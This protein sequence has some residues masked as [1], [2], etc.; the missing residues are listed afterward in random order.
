MSDTPVYN[1]RI[2]PPSTTGEVQDTQSANLAN[3]RANVIGNQWNAAAGV[4]R[5]V[6][7]LG[8]ASEGIF[9]KKKALT[10]TALYEERLLQLDGE[11]G[12]VP[13]SGQGG[14]GQLGNLNKNRDL[15]HD[16][17]SG[18]SA[19]PSEHMQNWTQARLDVLSEGLDPEYEAAFRQAAGE[20]L[21]K[22]GEK[23]DAMATGMAYSA[24][25]A[26]DQAV[27]TGYLKD[28]DLNDIDGSIESNVL[29]MASRINRGINMGVYGPEEGA[30][31]LEQFATQITGAHYMAASANIQDGDGWVDPLTS[32][33]YDG[34]DGALD[35]V[36]DKMATGELSE[37]DGTQIKAAINERD[38]E[39]YQVG[40]KVQQEMTNS[41][42][43]YF[44]KQMNLPEPPPGL[45]TSIINHKA[46]VPEKS[47]DWNRVGDQGTMNAL[48][49]ELDGITGSGDSEN[50][51][52]TIPGWMWTQFHDPTWDDVRAKQWLDNSGWERA[53]VSVEDYRWLYQKARDVD[54]LANTASIQKTVDLYYT[55]DLEAA[56]GD[57]VKTLQIEAEKMR[58]IGY[59][60]SQLERPE[61]TFK[62][63][64]T[65]LSNFLQTK[66]ED[67]I[68]R[69][70]VKDDVRKTNPAEMLGFFAQRGTL[71]GASAS[72]ALYENVVRMHEIH[73]EI[74]DGAYPAARGET[75]IRG[76]A[77]G[78]PGTVM[79]GQV[80]YKVW[81]DT[82]KN[83]AGGEIW[84]MAGVEKTPQ[85]G[86]EE[87]LLQM[88]EQPNLQ[89]K[90][91]WSPITRPGILDANST[92]KDRLERLVTTTEI[93]IENGYDWDQ[94]KARN[95]AA[96]VEENYSDRK[97]I[98]GAP[99]YAGISNHYYDLYKQRRTGI[100]LPYASVYDLMEGDL[101]RGR[102]SSA[103][104]ARTFEM[105][106][107]EIHDEVLK[108]IKND[109]NISIFKSNG[110][111]RRNAERA[112]SQALNWYGLPPEYGAIY[113]DEIVNP[114]R[115]SSPSS[116]FFP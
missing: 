5:G 77:Y 99:N 20:K 16:W 115:E 67:T 89:N 22:A 76:T 90:D 58:T 31:A 43:V 80:F 83:G 30:Q 86:L 2:G 78:T 29:D 12:S 114:P 42:A 52:A 17:Q 45:R 108:A 71:Q 68:Y 110:D 101:R 62:D 3:Q 96:W 32:E 54:S 98:V 75:N 47:A 34:L 88:D 33:F 97:D 100:Q 46:W 53:G 109:P 103:D 13:E 69:D 55:S 106:D 35:L 39:K 70:Y 11:I 4:A 116:V 81:D 64:P 113:L 15:L 51:G 21:L 63:V 92:E 104:V 105:I 74:I 57:A 23:I 84:V 85:G 25:R 38:Y 112:I 7:Q 28:P 26:T 72:P 36:D 107:D 8:A 102:I 49:R 87:Q 59:I 14:T 9:A 41:A 61:A 48:L 95:G 24:I 91:N 44:R 73:K 18:E 66:V 19:M 60:E 65:F 56:E 27:A 37:Y 50:R 1:P 111:V 93:D 10:Q 82:A 94:L 79:E 6:M 40:V